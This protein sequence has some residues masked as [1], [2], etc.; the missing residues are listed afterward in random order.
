MMAARM[1]VTLVEQLVVLVLLGLIAAMG[2]TLAEPV[3]PERQDAAA[4]VR[5]RIAE[6]RQEALRTGQ[7]VIVTVRQ[8]A[9]VFGATVLPNGEVVVDPLSLIRF[10]RLTGSSSK[11]GA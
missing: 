4:I 7:I 3:K 6:A 10:D 2:L 1:G 5:S 11:E 8:S 9:V